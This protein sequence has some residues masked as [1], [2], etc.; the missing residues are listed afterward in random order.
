M[1]IHDTKLTPAETCT[2][3]PRSPYLGVKN[4]TKKFDEST[5]LDDVS[6]DISKGEFICFLGPSGCGKTTLLRC[7]AGLETQ[8]AGQIIQSEKDISWLPPSARDFGIVFQSYALFPNLT[9]GDNVAYGLVNT[10]AKR[11]EIAEK[12]DGLLKLVNL[13]AHKSKYP[14]QLSGG[15]QQRIAL[16]RALATSPGLLLLDE[17]LSAL[18]AQVREHLRRE[19]RALQKRL[20]VTTIM[21]THDQDEALTMADRIVVMNAG[22]LEQIG[23]PREIYEEPATPFVARFIGETNVIPLAE[24]EHG[25]ARSGRCWLDISQAKSADETAPSGTDVIAVIRPEDVLIAQK[26]CL[27]TV[28]TDI[29]DV[30]FLGDH[31]TVHV[32]APALDS[33]R[34]SVRISKQQALTLDLSAGTRLPLCLPSQ[35]L[36]LLNAT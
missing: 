14:A 34:L 30:E 11:R 23:T 19:V 9:V 29:L 4:L 6:F 20:D 17:P 24:F 3:D 10:G 32:H 15:E 16:V 8:T 27:N 12:V 21:V 26:D 13:S 35:A 1:T 25:H 33:D 22:K 31:L 2:T 5:A 36:R 28:Q 18:D 7:I